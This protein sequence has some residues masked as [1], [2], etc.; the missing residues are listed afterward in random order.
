MSNRKTPDKVKNPKRAREDI[1]SSDPV[2]R[3]QEPAPRAARAAVSSESGAEVKARAATLTETLVPTPYRTYEDR[4]I[5]MNFGDHP[6]L[7]DDLLERALVTAQVVTGTG[8]KTVN[9]DT[10]PKAIHPAI[11]GVDPSKVSG[12]YQVTAN[13]HLP[14]T[15]AAVGANVAVPDTNLYVVVTASDGVTWSLLLLYQKAKQ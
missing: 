13:L 4:G 5:G 2:G 14:E 9:L 8:N 6:K 12:P 7:M 3:R 11:V 1:S 10:V 15:I